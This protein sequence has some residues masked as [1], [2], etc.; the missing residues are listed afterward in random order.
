MS[1]RPHSSDPGCGVPSGLAGRVVHF[2]DFLRGQGFRMFQSSV[3]DALRSI[4]CL[5]LDRDV[6]AAALR[7]N[8]CTNQLE[9]S[10]F[11]ELFDRFWLDIESD[12]AP[13]PE[14]APANG[15]Q[16][17]GEDGSSPPD[18]PEQDLPAEKVV[19]SRKPE[20]SQ[21]WMEG[22]T[23]SPISKIGKKD[24][25]RFEQTEIPV[26]RLALKRLMEPFRI[27]RSRR[28]KAA[29]KHG[30]LD[31]RRIMRRS[32]KYE[33]IPVELFFR[34]KKQRLKRL[35]I[36]A[37]VS[38][39]MDKYARF[40]MPFLLGLRG[41]GS[42][43]EVF[44]F[45]TVLQSITFVVKHLSV[46]KAIQRMSEEMPEWSGGT[47]IGYSLHQFNTTQGMRMLNRRTVILIL[48]DGWDL[49]GKALLEKE[50]K[51]LHR[52]AHTVIWLNPL[53]GDPGY[54]PVCRGMQAALPYI[55]HFMPATSLQD[56]NQVGHL[57]SRVMV[58]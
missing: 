11:G 43:A 57:L 30:R 42:K 8:L 35:V 51:I 17:E 46:E 21:E 47:R 22:R 27:E 31:F 56:L 18:Q 2:A 12:E 9:W 39:S 4:D 28:P 44:V 19:K 5:S 24:L 41:I 7:T 49:G 45:S 33:G 32:L 15:A 36:L 3:H 6:F 25:S 48:S 54:Q 34:R 58:H 14:P 55:H 37:D 40:I 10:Q 52:K 20:P 1:R 26:A 53:A 29:P 38:G 50:M 13:P 23:Y 16:D